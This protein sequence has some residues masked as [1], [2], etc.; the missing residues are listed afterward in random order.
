MA[1]P[2]FGPVPDEVG[3]C[4][5]DS[6]PRPVSLKTPFGSGELEASG[7]GP[8]ALSLLTPESR[9]LW[10]ADLQI[11]TG[12]SLAASNSSHFRFQFYM[13]PYEIAQDLFPGSLRQN[14]H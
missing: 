7:H 4:C 6:P 13:S 8:V 9:P 10:I 11:G 12:L 2:I 1:G 3:D 5:S 14:I